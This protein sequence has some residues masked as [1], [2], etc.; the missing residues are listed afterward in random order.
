MKKR[1]KT[2]IAVIA[3]AAILI[4]GIWMINESRYPNVPAFD[5]HFTREFLNKDKKVDDGFYEFKSKT[6][7]YT[8][9]FPEEY[10]LIHENKED[11]SINGKDYERWVA[12]SENFFNNK[13]EIS[14]INVELTDKVKKNEDI[15]V[16]SVFKKNLHVNMPKKIETANASIYYDSAYTY[17]KGTEEKVVKNN[18]K[19]VP[20]TYVAYIA[21]KDTDRVIELYYKYTGEELTEKQREKQEK[22]IV[23][24]L[25]SVNFHEEK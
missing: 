2:I 8:M 15:N 14:Y 25:Q 21:D 5:D 18:I 6:G 4:G 19:Y 1:T 24:I 7:Q 23:K 11:Y 3:G 13:S 16:E 9:W 17:F 10:Q 20:N 12:S 22:L